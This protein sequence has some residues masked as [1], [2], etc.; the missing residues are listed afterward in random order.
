MNDKI[1]KIIDSIKLLDQ[2]QSIGL[3]TGKCG[4][5]LFYHYCSLMLKDNE[6]SKNCFNLIDDAIEEIN[7]GEILPTYCSGI[8]GFGWTL[9][10]LNQQK[11]LCEID[12]ELLDELDGF[13]S[14]KMISDI[15]SNNYDFLHG[16]IGYGFYF[17]KRLDN[18]KC[19]DYLVELVEN[20][21][22]ISIKDKDGSIKWGSIKYDS[23]GE[24]IYNI[25]LSHGL[26]SIINVLTRIYQAEIK[27]EKC[28]YLI[29]GA[30]KYL[31]KQEIDHTK[32]NSYFPIWSIES[33]N[34]LSGS[35]LGWCYGDLGIAITLW[36]AGMA[37]NNSAWK[38]KAIEVLKHAATRRDLQA[39]LVRDAGLCHGTAG[40]GHIFYRMW[41]NTRLPEFKDAADYW[42]N[43]TLKMAYHKDGLAGYKAW[44]GEQYGGWQNEV[45]LLEGVAGIGLALMTYH[46]EME[47]SWDECLL[48]S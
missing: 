21:H 15:H 20:L 3:Y 41:W 35:R 25:S 11:A 33:D 17:L 28:E 42:F 14:R 16:A 9:A 39:N 12:I 2:T 18:G 44:Q 29:N 43:E 26:A 13:L 40:I 6:S 10:Y 38:E 47:P 5:A 22:Q 8:A 7:N 4:I 27:R 34:V 36:Q 31:L 46:Y 24:I 37:F 23:N 30:I 45:G 19:V 48:L 32:Y 1:S